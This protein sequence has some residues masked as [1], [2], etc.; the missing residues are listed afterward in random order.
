MVDLHAFL[1]GDK[2]EPN[3]QFENECLH[4]AQN[5]R[6]QVLLRVG[7]FETQE[8]EHI[9]IAEHQIGR[10][11]VLGLECIEFPPNELI[12]LFRE[13]RALE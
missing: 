12:G 8:I 1:P 13:C 7:V 10:E 4:L 9:R 6:F 3:A 5:G 11:L 2:T